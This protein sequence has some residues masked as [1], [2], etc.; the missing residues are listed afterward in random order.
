MSN[1]ILTLLENALVCNI[2]ITFY[3]LH[4]NIANIKRNILNNNNN[5]KYMQI[6]THIQTH[7]KYYI[8][9]IE[10][11]KNRSLHILLHMG[12]YLSKFH[13]FVFIYSHHDNV[14]H[15][16]F[17]VFHFLVALLFHCIL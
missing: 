13:S 14:A 6:H 5:N 9:L 16:T 15:Q 17:N 10:I 7:T 4:Y 2:I 12:I 8:V 3:C 11:Q 1:I